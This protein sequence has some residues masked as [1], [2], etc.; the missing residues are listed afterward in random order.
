MGEICMRVSHFSLLPGVFSM[1][2][3][4]SF[5]Y[6][7]PCKTSTVHSVSQF[8]KVMERLGDTE[9]E[10]VEKDKCVFSDCHYKILL[11]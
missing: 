3:L 5:R 7:Q 8:S 10:Q 1:H 11:G 9:K 6:I 2:A 4:S